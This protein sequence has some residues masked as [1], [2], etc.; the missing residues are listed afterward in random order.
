MPVQ[1]DNV[2]LFSGGLDSTTLL[3]ALAPNVKALLV[4]YG[5]RHHVELEHA[6]E[7]C[8]DAR[9]GFDIVD[10]SHI[11]P[12]IATGSQAG[13]DEVPEGHYAEES[14]RATVVPNRNMIMLAIAIG[15]AVK[16][17][18]YKV[19]LA[20]HAGDHAVYPDCR[21][22][23]IS[24]MNEAAILGNAWTPVRVIAP[25]IH[26]TKAQIVRLGTMIHVPYEKTWSCYK[27]L[28][29]HCGKCGTCVERREA[30]QLA[31]VKDPTIYA[32]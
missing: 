21:P 22:E 1:I 13:R 12:L 11:N 5:Q 19:Q 3:W 25:Y 17:G 14:M 28:Q 29:F 26:M 15:H 23:F 10:L 16:I 18:A 30:F 7:L 6:A 2:M 31:E 24:A 9:V 20:V 32:F 4:D 8:V 27:G